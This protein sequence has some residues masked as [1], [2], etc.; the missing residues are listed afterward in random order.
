MRCGVRPAALIGHSVGEFVAAALAGVMSLRRRARGW[1]PRARRADAGAARG[2]DAVGAAAG[3]ATSSRGCPPGS[4]LAAENGP[5]LCV[6]AG[7]TDADRARS[8]P[9]LEAEGVAAKPLQTSH[10]FH[11]PM[12][13]RAV[14]PFAALVRAV[15]LLGAAHADRLDRCTGALLSDAEATDPSYWARHLR[16]TGALLAG[17][18]RSAARRPSAALL[19]EVGPRDTL[20]TLARQHATRQRA[21]P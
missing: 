6:V 15:A 2:R 17:A 14:A 5:T 20:A 1:W 18:L 7:P 10:A 21:E 3:G 11:S 8:Q 13:D 16:A 4:S 9:T 19:L 12:M